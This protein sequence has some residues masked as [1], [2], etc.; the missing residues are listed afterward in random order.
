MHGFLRTFTMVI[1]ILFACSGI[2]SEGKIY[3][4]KDKDGKIHFSDKPPKDQSIAFEE[5][6][7]DSSKLTV[8]SMPRSQNLALLT[9]EQCQAAANNLK[10]TEPLYRGELVEQLAKK[11]IN[12]EQFTHELAQLDDVKRII[13]SKDCKASQPEDLGLLQCIAQKKDARQCLK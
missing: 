11:E 3:K 2:A 12:N 8:T 5:Q 13:S 1:A 7:V 10:H 6:K 9:K 4:W